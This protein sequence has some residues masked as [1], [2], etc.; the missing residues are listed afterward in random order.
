MPIEPI[1]V[2]LKPPPDPFWVAQNLARLPHLI[3]FDSAGGPSELTRY[4]YISAAPFEW[5]EFQ[6]SSESDPFEV[7]RE[8]LAGYRSSSIANLPPFQGGAA[9]LFSYELCH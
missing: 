7:L 3:W 6:P 2:E 9:G 4:S 1:A 8:K 5:L